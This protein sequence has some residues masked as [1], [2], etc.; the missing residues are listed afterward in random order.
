MEILFIQVECSDGQIG[1]GRRRRRA[2]PTL[3]ADP[4]KIF[5]ITITSFIKVNYDDDTENFEDLFKNQTKTYNNK[6]LIVG[7]QM[8][9][10]KRFYKTVNGNQEDDDGQLA[11][12]NDISYLEKENSIVILTSAANQFYFYSA[13]LLISLVAFI[14]YLL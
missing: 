12:S 14:R 2:I 5:E 10:D 8:Q 6:K 3:P 9:D 7:N 4:N 1:Y 11:N 13:N